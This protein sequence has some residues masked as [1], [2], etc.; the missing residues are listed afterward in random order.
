MSTPAAASAR[1]GASARIRATQKGSVPARR[2][3]SC[4]TRAQPGCWSHRPYGVGKSSVAVE[5]VTL[6]KEK[7]SHYGLVDVD[8]LGWFDVGAGDGSELH[9][10][11]RAANL[12]AVVGNFHAA[13]V[14]RFIL[15]RSVR[16]HTEVR[17]AEAAGIPLRVAALR[18]PLAVVERRLSADPT[19]SPGRP[20]RR[21]PVVRRRHRRGPRRN[22]HRQRPPDPDGGD[23]TAGVARLVTGHSPT[24]SGS[25]GAPCSRTVASRPAMSR[26]AN[27]SEPS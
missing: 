8:F 7:G 18:V 19:S 26:G 12:T 24:T 25:A 9:R 14:R 5:L 27:R 11:T 22:R 4:P 6:L 15:P 10:R 20:A 13:G 16:D 3:R 2:W 17:A 1:T 21:P 23:R